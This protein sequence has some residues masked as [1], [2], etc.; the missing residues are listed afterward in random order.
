MQLRLLWDSFIFH[1][2]K[3]DSNETPAE[4]M[5]KLAF[6]IQG[7]GKEGSEQRRRADLKKAEIIAPA[8]EAEG[9]HL[10]RADEFSTASITEPITSA[11][12]TSALVVADLGSLP[13]NQNVLVEV[14]F[15]LATGR[16]MVFV[17]DVEPDKTTLPTHLQD[18]RIIA[19]PESLTDDAIGR[20]RDVIKERQREQQQLES[21]S[22]S[23][24]WQSDYPLIEF[25]AP[26]TGGKPP[27]FV[28]VNEAAAALYGFD[29]ADELLSV[30]VEEAD[31]KLQGYMPE[32][33]REQFR[34]DQGKLWGAAIKPGRKEPVMARVPAWIYRQ[35]R[36]KD[37]QNHVYWPVMLQ[38]KFTR[39]KTGAEQGV[40]MR[41]AF[42]DVTRW[43]SE[44][45]LH[46]EPDSVIELPG[47]FRVR[48][49]KHHIFLSY[50]AKDVDQVRVLHTILKR[51]G[52]RVWFDEYDM[53]Q[54][55]AMTKT[56]LREMADSRMVMAVLG[57]GGL[58][59][60]QESVELSSKL[61]GVLRNDQ[62][63]ALLL[64][65]GV[66][67]PRRPDLWLSYLPTEF[68]DPFR[69]RLR[70]DLPKLSELDVLAKKGVSFQDR[71][72]RLLLEAI[73]QSFQAAGGGRR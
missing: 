31:E 53:L 66:Q 33:H 60:W 28:M 35:H 11:L 59:G 2:K 38:H 45:V 65:E 30:S 32:T 22:E 37:R 57:T 25:F 41:V 24:N 5:S 64:L 69:D 3:V 1:N 18:R 15:R 21:G 51:I 48:P 29:T 10:M 6:L 62:P 58:G 17:A 13:W 61:L 44:A 56:L 34:D 43:Q 42:I 67:D 27:Y 7:F 70:L 36:V 71:V 63:F 20:L 19:L 55:G 40:L 49:F 9:Y 52:L 47:Y 72:V 14:G 26:L 8:C 39:D 12:A 16:P 23:P 73:D 68:Q 54:T 4:P 50:N 46:S